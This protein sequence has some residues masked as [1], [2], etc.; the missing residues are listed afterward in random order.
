MSDKPKPQAGN[1]TIIYLAIW[2]FF[3]LLIPHPMGDW[4]GVLWG[5]FSGG[6]LLL[7]IGFVGAWAINKIA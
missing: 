4:P 1:A 7:E 3:M 2:V 5:V 6:V